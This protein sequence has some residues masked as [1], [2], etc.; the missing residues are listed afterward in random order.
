MKRRNPP[1]NWILKSLSEPRLR[2]GT[3]QRYRRT[4]KTEKTEE[5]TRKRILRKV[6][7][8]KGDQ[9]W[10]QKRE[11]K[12]EPPKKNRKSEK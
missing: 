6:S 12:A 7:P 5:P 4:V 8:N 11:A 10:G 3:G 9:C 2:T 1:T